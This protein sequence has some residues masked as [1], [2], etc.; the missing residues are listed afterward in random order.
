M[1]RTFSLRR[2]MIGVT[3][4]CL[5]CALVAN[6]PE[7]TYQAI[8]G[9]G[10]FVPT[11]VACAVL[12][13]FSSRPL[14]TLCGAIAGAIVGWIFFSYTIYE[15]RSAPPDW[16]DMYCYTFQTEAIPAATGAFVAGFACVGLFPR[17]IKRQSRTDSGV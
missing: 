9:A 16:W 14:L 5:L 12:P 13:W 6:F 8:L 4:L 15:S 17:W 10:F 3:V 11:V 1:S 2:L 7:I